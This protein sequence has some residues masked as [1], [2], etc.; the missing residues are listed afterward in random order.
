MVK[1]SFYAILICLVLMACS[2]NKNE[3]AF[4][5]TSN[6]K[7]SSAD[8]TLT[9][10][11]AVNDTYCKQTACACIHDIAA[12]EYFDIQKRLK[13][14]YNID[15]KL[16]Y[17]MESY[18]ME[19]A[20]KAKKF[21]GVICKPW[22][23]F[24]LN[25]DYN[26]KYRRVADVLDAFN[27]Q[28]LTGV[29]LVRKDSDIHCLEDIKGQTL[30][31]GQEDAYEKYH[32]PF[33]LLDEKGIQP[34]R[35]YQKASCLECINELMDKNTDVALVSDYVMKASCAVDVASEDDFRIIGETEKIPLC[36]VIMDMA[37]ISEAD[38]LR[39][40]NALLAV[41]GKKSEES[42]LS[43]GFVKPASWIPNPYLKPIAKN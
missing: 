34:G 19:D 11:L 41:S 7:A 33:R 28:W 14:D 42:L 1:N 6:L 17:F 21:D 15:L 22:T 31:A 36:S 39:L 16:S 35:V 27:N 40:Q 32:S 3:T 5:P 4:Q 13:T 18:E 20:M 10:N 9:I 25:E 23:A 26:I 37:K 43:D 29:F 12:R 2:S 24:M 38:A 8:Q 30:V